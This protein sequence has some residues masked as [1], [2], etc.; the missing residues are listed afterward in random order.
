MLEGSTTWEGDKTVY[1][2]FEREECGLFW[3]LVSAVVITADRPMS[4]GAIDSQRCQEIVAPNDTTK[5]GAHDVRW[6]AIKLEAVGSSLKH[7]ERGGVDLP[8]TQRDLFRR[9]PRARPPGHART[10]EYNAINGLHR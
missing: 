9:T 7:C 2:R 5:A 4:V 8:H 1:E 10:H 6:Q 3:T